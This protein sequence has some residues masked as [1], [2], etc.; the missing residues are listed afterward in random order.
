MTPISAVIITFN[1]EANIRSCIAALQDVADQ[2]LVI[3]SFSRDQTLAICN[4]LGADVI[5]HAFEGYIEQKNYAIAQAKFDHILS[6]DADEVIDDELMQSIKAVK[7]HWAHDGYYL[8]R[9]TNYCGQWIRHC[10]WHPEWKLR[11]WDRKKG[12][13]GGE[14]PHDM[15]ILDQNTSTQRLTGLLLHYSYP[16]IGDHIKTMNQFSEIKATECYKQNKR[17]N[18]LIHVLLNPP[19]TFFKKFILQQGFL[20]G[21]YGFVVST[22]SAVY[23]FLKYT[24]A[25]ERFQ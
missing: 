10:G 6:I 2:I 1:E 9:L 24:K 8:N 20:D 4:E 3:D 22:L 25:R 17:P 13:W 15:V 18:L 21:Y 12:H 16:S 14:N 7:N 11:L 23:N 5:Q 19:F